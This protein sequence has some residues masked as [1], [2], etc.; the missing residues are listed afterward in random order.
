MQEYYWLHKGTILWRHTY[1][2]TRKCKHFSYPGYQCLLISTYPHAGIVAIR[3]QMIEFATLCAMHVDWSWT[4]KSWQYWGF[5]GTI[6]TNWIEHLVWFHY[7][8][9][10]QYV[11]SV[12]VYT[13]MLYYSNNAR[14]VLIL[15]QYNVQSSLWHKQF[16]KCRCELCYSWV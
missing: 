13:G 15:T 3:V 4:T 12:Y 10:S 14:I 9:F 11:W 1:L 2:E 5:E 16:V 6:G 8:G 7:G